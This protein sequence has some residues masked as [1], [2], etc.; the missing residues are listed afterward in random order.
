M[1]LFVLAVVVALPVTPAA[2]Q[3]LDTALDRCLAGIE[4]EAPDA[5][6]L[7]QDVCP[8]LVAVLA[9][10]PWAP[11]LEDEVIGWMTPGDA[12]ALL[13]L[14]EA[15]SSA[16]RPQGRPSIESLAAALAALPPFDPPPELSLWDQIVLFL[17]DLFGVDGEGGNWLPDW[18]RNLAL[19]DSWT[20]IAVWAIGAAI[21][22]AAVAVVLNELRHAGFFTRVGRGE[23]GGG[24]DPVFERGRKLP[25]T[26]ENVRAAPTA[27]QPA[28]L[29]G[30]VLA[31][32]RSRYGR[33]FGD[34]LTHR[35]LV[36]AA[37]ATDGLDIEG[38]RTVVNAAER[39]T[40]ADWRPT[41]Q[42]LEP[43]WSSGGRLLEAFDAAESV[44]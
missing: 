36:R 3:G 24:R 40:F 11:A 22:L 16:G 38:F 7:I 30:L 8:D 23:R 14:E 29:L 10:S 37:G 41:A 9:R 5:V 26:L 43:L 27:E 39:S 6:L 44:R 20:E 17:E 42:E 35:E 4:D 1:R 32:L 15:Y 28:L 18:L 21:V 33:I 13:T 34:E 25:L 19:P 31:R 2:A 12:V